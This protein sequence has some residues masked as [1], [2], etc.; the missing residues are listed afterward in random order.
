MNYILFDIGGTNTRVALSNDLE[1]FG[2]PKKY[3]TPADNFMVGIDRLKATIAELCPGEITAFAG[4][5]RGLLNKYKTGILSDTK[6]TAWENKNIVAQLSQT[7]NNAPIYLEN[8][9]AVVGL[10]EAVY[11]AGVGSEIMAYHTVSTGVGGVRIVRG[12]IDETTVGFEPGKQI[13]D[14]D[15]SVLGSDKVNSLENLVSGDALEEARGVKPYDI[16]QS[17]EVWNQLAF[18]L[19]QGLRN[20]VTYWSPDRIVLGGAMIFGNP[21]IQLEDIVRHT[22]ESLGVILPC[23]EIVDGTLRDDGGLYGAMAL[24]KQHL[25][26]QT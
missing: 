10:G 6:L 24:L 21:R 19:S 8:D 17:D 14:I 3:D 2:K 5:I 9:A 11:G 15:R 18:Y 1:A 12:K 4:S 25:N 23:P 13:L 26:S 7:F 20:T 16:P 22:Q